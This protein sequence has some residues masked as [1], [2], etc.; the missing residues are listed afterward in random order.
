MGAV[1]VLVRL[2]ADLDASR[3]DGITAL[4]A[5]A[6]RG[7]VE[8]ARVLLAGGADR[9]LKATNGFAKGMTALEI[10]EDKHLSEEVADKHFGDKHFEA[11]AT[12]EGFSPRSPGEKEGKDAVAALLRE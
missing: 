7:K 2:G 11:P 10:A 1:S 6:A 5:A 8:C 3:S 4:M 9:T 12:G